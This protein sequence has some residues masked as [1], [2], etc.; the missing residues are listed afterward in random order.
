VY[1]CTQKS[2]SSHH[3]RRAALTGRQ[4]REMAVFCKGVFTGPKHASA[5]SF[6]QSA[7]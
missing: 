1:S 4:L 7:L 2:M 6:L 3:I 5:V